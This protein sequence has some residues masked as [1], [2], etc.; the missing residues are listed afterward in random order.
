MQT[1]RNAHRQTL[2][3]SATLSILLCCT[4]CQGFN[5]CLQLQECSAKTTVQYNTVFES[6]V[7]IVCVCVKTSVSNGGLGM[8]QPNGFYLI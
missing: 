4:I 8:C 6:I 3:T 2:R 1:L 5:R 7:S